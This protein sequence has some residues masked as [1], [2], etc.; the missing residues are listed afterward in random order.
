METFAFSGTAPLFFITSGYLIGLIYFQKS[1]WASTARLSAVLVS[2]SAHLLAMNCTLFVIAL[3]VMS[4]DR[5]FYETAFYEAMFQVQTLSSDPYW[6]ALSLL[7]LTYQLPLL[8]ILNVYILLL[9]VGVPFVFIV[10]A[11]ARMGLALLAASYLFAQFFPDIS[12]PGGNQWSH[13]LWFFN[14]FAWSVFVLGGMM[15]GR[16]RLHERLYEA[17][18]A[19][20]S[21]KVLVLGLV[22][23]IG[24]LAALRLIAPDSL[25]AGPLAAKDTAGPL[26]LIHA[27]LAFT[28]LLALL[29]RYDR[30]RAWAPVNTV[31]N[32]FMV[33]G[34]SSLHAFMAGVILDYVMV[35]AWARL[36]G[37][38]AIYLIVALLGICALVFYVTIVEVVKSARNG[39]LALPG[40]A[41][42][43]PP[44]DA[45]PRTALPPAPGAS[46]AA[47]EST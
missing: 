37:G 14:P 42:P 28:T 38:R 2:R 41:R 23:A 18:V 26:Y 3:A 16:A 10:R 4:V 19:P 17:A 1:D 45:G 30:F 33:V 35:L 21:G 39:R 13:G 22:A 25:L 31:F 47:L 8:E 12:M 43:A 44:G 7:T 24:T 29:F 34:R 40:L 36:G 5:T 46:P 20:R 15:A 6:W 27:I 11:N 32:L 9:A